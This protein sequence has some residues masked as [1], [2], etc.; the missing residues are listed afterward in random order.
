MAFS[1][2]QAGTSLQFLDSNQNLS[3]L[4]LPSNIT[5]NSNIPPRFVIFGNYVTIVNTPNFPI[6]VDTSGTVRPLTPKPPATAPILSVGTAGG[7]TGTYAGVRVTFVVKDINGTVISESDFSPASPSIVVTAQNILVTNI[8][9]SLETISARR[10]Y[11]PTTLGTVL[12]PWLD[13]DGNTVTSVQDDLADAGLSLLP[14]PLLGTP[15]RL[16]LIK[17]WRNLLWGVGDQDIDT[18][19]FSRPEAFYS[20]PVTNNIPVPGSGKDKFG[21]RS[22]MPRREALGVGR[23]DIIWQVTGS[24]VDDF[25]LVKL[26]EN[27]GIES[28]ESMV[29]YRD[30]VFW[31]WKDGVYQWDDTGIVNI[32]DSGVSSWFNTNNYFNTNMFSSAFAIM[33]IVR[34][35][36]KLYLASAG[37]TTI[38]SWV[39]YD[40]TTKKW[41]GP[42]KTDAFSPT[43]VFQLSDEA[44]KITTVIGS[45]SGFI[46]KEQSIATDDISTPI[47]I[48]VDTK[49]YDGGGPDFDKFWG[50]LSMMGK[51]Q[52]SGVLQITPKVGYLGSEAR[53]VIVYDMTKG[54]QRLGRMGVGKN[55]QLNF[56][57]SIAG[58]PIELY[59][60]QIP[61]HIIGHR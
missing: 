41:W 19:V 51:T 14:A 54:R 58:E 46:W 47:S 48:D 31:L 59:G 21:I 6:T 15:P 25:A 32:S 35:K 36:Y 23:R 24:T 29:V 13:V 55:L 8:P 22:L 5:L 18:L 4:T 1:I 34:L 42:H 11:R 12:F 30:T 53:P 37:S 44:D 49:N 45:E 57:H 20:W 28:N 39:E 3:T 38:D 60:F 50:E 27:T 56:K 52:T 40:L 17:E 2:I 61:Y 10:L 26:S 7:L 9:T 16:T 33:D 43:C